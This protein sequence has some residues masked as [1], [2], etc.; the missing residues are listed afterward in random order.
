MKRKA[1]TT[2]DELF[3]RC[4]LNEETGCLEWARSIN[5]NGY[6]SL[7]FR[8]KVETAHRAAYSLHHG[9]VLTSDNVICHECDNPIC[10]NLDHLF[11]G[12]HKDNSDDKFR[13]G[14]FKVLRGEDNGHTKVSDADVIEIQRLYAETDLFQREIGDM[15]GITQAQ[16]SNIV[17][18]KQRNY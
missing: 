13:K 3:E 10:C 15:Y 9:V 12:T 16:V 11:L 8:G 6:G 2:L 18:N 1:V 17:L 7:R 5:G 14:R 4:V